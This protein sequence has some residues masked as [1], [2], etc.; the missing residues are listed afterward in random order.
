MT[1]EPTN[2]VRLVKRHLDFVG[3]SWTLIRVVDDHTEANGFPTRHEAEQWA[4][5]HGWSVKP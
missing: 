5:E 1:D 3:D 4:A 2:L